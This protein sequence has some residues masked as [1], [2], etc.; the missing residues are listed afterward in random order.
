MAKTNDDIV[1]QLI[2]PKTNRRL[3][4]L[5]ASATLNLVK[6]PKCLNG[7]LAI[8]EKE[9]TLNSE[10]A[11]IKSTAFVL[12]TRKVLKKQISVNNKNGAKI[13]IKNGNQ[14]KPIRGVGNIQ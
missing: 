10:P 2:A 14:L 13:Q 5:K 11:F 1:K 12:K 6:I 4:E 7:F 9:L 8:R 3:I